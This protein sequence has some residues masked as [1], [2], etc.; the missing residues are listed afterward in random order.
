MKI[1]KISRS[2]RKRLWRDRRNLTNRIERMSWPVRDV[3]EYE[4]LKN[5]RTAI[6]IDIDRG[7]EVII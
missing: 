1:R 4:I 5:W 7:F 3:L 2:R 6:T